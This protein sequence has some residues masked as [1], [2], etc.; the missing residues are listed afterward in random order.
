MTT[1]SSFLVLNQDHNTTPTT[2]PDLLFNI[3]KLVSKRTGWGECSASLDAKVLTVQDPTLIFLVID[4]E[5]LGI[6]HGTP[7]SILTKEE[8]NEIRNLVISS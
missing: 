2:I 1:Q 3:G 7:R 4:L 8:L 5:D 6:I